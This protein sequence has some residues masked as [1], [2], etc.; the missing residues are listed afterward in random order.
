MQ[1][2]WLDESILDQQ[3][4]GAKVANLSRLKKNN[5]AVPKGFALSTEVHKSYKRLQAFPPELSEELTTKLKQIKTAKVIVRS[6]AVGEDSFDTSFAGQLESY[7]CANDLSEV[8]TYI[9]KCWDSIDSERSLVYQLSKNKKLENMGVLVQ[10]F[11]EPEYAGVLFTQNPDGTNTQVAEYVT[12][13]A[14]DLV[15]GKVNPRSVTFTLSHFSEKV[16]FN[17]QQLAFT[18]EMILKEMNSIPQDIEWIQLDNEIQ[19]VQTRPITQLKRKV[20]WSNTNVNEN[21]PIALLPLQNSISRFAYSQYFRNLA[22]RLDLLNKEL[23]HNTYFSNI[24]GF[25]N[26]HMYYN[27]TSILTLIKQTPMSKFIENS[28]NEFVGYQDNKTNQEK[29]N[30]FSSFKALFKL[31]KYTLFLSKHVKNFEKLVSDFSNKYDSPLPSQEHVFAYHDFLEI[32]FYKWFDA[33]LADFFAMFYHGLL[34]KVVQSI[35]PHGNK[36]HHNRLLQSIP[37]LISNRPIIDLWEI[38]QFIEKQ[39][40]MNFFAMSSPE[41]IYNDLQSEPR[42]QQLNELVDQ[43]L[44]KWGYRCSGELVLNW[45]SHL[46]SPISFFSFLKSYLKIESNDPQAIFANQR[47]DSLKLKKE[48]LHKVKKNFLVKPLKSLALY[49]AFKLVLPLAQ[50]GIASRERVRLKQALAFSIF[51]K[52][53]KQIGA[54]WM[55]QG[56]LKDAMDIHYL[57]YD[58]I[59]FL[60]HGESFKENAIAELLQLRK[61]ISFEK[62]RPDDFYSFQGVYDDAYVEAN[63]AIESGLR[64]LSAC[65]GKITGPV[66]ILESIADID[67]LK[68]GDILVTRQTDPGWV[69][70]F[71]LISGI[72]IE[73]GGVLSHG[74]IVAREFGIPAVVG[75]KSATQLLKDGQTVTIYGDTGQIEC[76]N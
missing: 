29:Q 31:A 16:D 57:K 12:G 47:A 9:Q 74:A 13:F 58:E 62:K 54:S 68:R 60:L 48:L 35:D 3:Y 32:R 4:F 37:N 72:I 11:R 20:V 55:K 56:M 26:G 18:S 5:I 66:R 25:W 49:S 14:G 30:I 65:G 71:P 51:R 21:Y 33:S 63:L 64:G 10:A 38:R 45:D 19:I 59:S 7:I 36:S 15:S 75:V 67:K 43:Y 27:M 52:T 17:I 1:M 28:F 70:V 53:I 34:N 40:L 41:Q 23:S 44:K 6:S 46:E 61:N 24:I 8:K 2:P 42:Y 22:D 50:L 76:H 39:K 69:C 73:R